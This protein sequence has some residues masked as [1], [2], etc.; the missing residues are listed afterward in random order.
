MRKGLQKPSKSILP[1]ERVSVVSE[2]MSTVCVLDIYVC[3][4]ACV[5]LLSVHV[6]YGFS[7]N[8]TDIKMVYTTWVKDDV[9][10]HIHINT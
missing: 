1:G 3:V 2:S 7:L 9:S 10:I 6:C 4:R 8:L 5:R